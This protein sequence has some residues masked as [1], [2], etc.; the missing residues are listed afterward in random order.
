MIYNFDE[1][2]NRKAT[3]S[4]KWHAF[5]ED[6]LPMWVADMDFLSPEP[7]IRALQERVAHGVF[8]YAGDMP[9]LSEAIV[10]RLDRLYHWK[11]TPKDL[12]FVPGVVT[13]F[14][15]AAQAFV[16][17]NGG[18][19]IQP[20]VYMPFLRVANNVGGIDQEAPLTPHSDGYYTVD[21]DRF[22]SAITDQ[23]RM[24]LLCNPHN[25]VGR[26]F[27]R[28]ELERMAAI[29]LRHNLVICSD[30][31]HGDLIFSG[32]QHVPVASIDPEIAQK[33]VTL[34]APSKTFNIAG[35]S[36]SFAVI[37]NPTLRKQFEQGG[38]GMV[39]GVN[40]LGLVAAQAAYQHGQEWLD[41]MLAYLE[42]NRNVLVRFVNEQLPGVKIFCPE[43]TYLAWLDCRNA[44]LGDKPAEFFHKT[45][46]VALNE[47]DAF[48]QQGAGFVR[49]NF[50]CP[51]SMLLEALERMKKALLEK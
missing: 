2:P 29:C 39:H 3:E 33:T 43:G 4:V 18:L 40:L 23:T 16:G 6:V 37:Q 15:M 21:D 19:L 7:V 45:A 22:E 42:E 28:D 44:G 24:F 48:G 47:G 14:N 35:L 38:L 46:R 34:M 11:V 50:G 41:Q 17:A 51:R 1:L 12:V 9:A 20:P 36:C 26:V 32:H 49:L 5:E 30:E 25:P 10:E 31:I 8:G 13:G 27:H